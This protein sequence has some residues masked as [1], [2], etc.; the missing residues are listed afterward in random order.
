MVVIQDAYAATDLPQGGVAAIGNFNKVMEYTPAGKVNPPSER[1]GVG[2]PRVVTMKLPDVPTLKVTLLALV[3]ADASSGAD[4]SSGADFSAC[5]SS[6]AA[7]ARWRLR[8][9][10]A[11]PSVSGTSGVSSTGRPS[12]QLMR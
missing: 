4:T 2:K 6:A 9:A 12:G 7:S 3:I 10:G 5:A 8:L 1:V 11:A